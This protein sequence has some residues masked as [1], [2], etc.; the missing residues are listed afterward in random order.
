MTEMEKNFRDLEELY[1]LG[2]L[3][4]EGYAFQK[5]QLEEMAREEAQAATGGTTPPPD[6]QTAAPVAPAIN[7]DGMSA[8]DIHDQ[9]GA[10]ARA[11]DYA[12]AAELWQKAA[13]L[14]N[15]DAQAALGFAY[16]LGRGVTQDSAKAAE[17]FR[18]AAEQG[19][20]MAIVMLKR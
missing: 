14:G 20:S 9:G 6:Q 7:T 19:D 2:M 10:A 5:K 12:K 16:E 15:A 3:D 8:A 13:E 11:G 17:W 1:K 18:K 4:A